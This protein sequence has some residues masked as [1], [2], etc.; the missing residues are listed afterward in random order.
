MKRHKARFNPHDWPDGQ[1]DEDTAAFL[2]GWVA[3]FATQEVTAAEA[4]E[5]S[6]ALAVTPPNFRREH[7][8][9]VMAKI[10]EI[11]QRRGVQPGTSSREAIRDASRNCPY[12]AG[13][14]LAMAWAVKPDAARRISE[15]VAAYCT[16]QHGRWIKRTHAEKSP[17]M[18]RRILDFGEV[19]DGVKPGWLGHPPGRPELLATEPET[20]PPIEAEDQSRAVT[21]AAI[22]EMFRVPK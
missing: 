1:D 2:G 11:R 10:T 18:L 8:P 21:K 5:A 4:E 14:G 15:T 19:L 12:C 7:L 3:A 9:M 16:C 13:D 22:S 17:E 20:T 6:E